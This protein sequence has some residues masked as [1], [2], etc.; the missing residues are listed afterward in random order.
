MTMEKLIAA[1]LQTTEQVAS[2]AARAGRAREKLRKAAE[3]LVEEAV[4]ELNADLFVPYRFGRYELLVYETGEIR[5][6]L[7]DLS[8][9]KDGKK[10][11]AEIFDGREKMPWLEGVREAFRKKLALPPE[12]RFWIGIDP[13]YFMEDK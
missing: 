7:R 1:V 2:A 9:A 4:G 13:Y 3:P 11:S 12:A 10:C 5:I 8:H 6:T